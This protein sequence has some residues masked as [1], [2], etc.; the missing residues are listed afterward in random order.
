L[1]EKSTKD[2][3]NLEQE[4]KDQYSDKIR[5]YKEREYDLQKQL[6]QALDQLT[7]LRQSHDDTQAQ[8]IGHD[9]KYGKYIKI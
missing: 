7:D 2:T 6:N 9:Q 8:L 3:S 5:Q 1:V 4:M